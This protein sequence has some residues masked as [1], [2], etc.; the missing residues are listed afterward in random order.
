M[1]MFSL[2]K[3]TGLTAMVAGVA[4]G[5]ASVG[6]DFKYQG[7][8]SLELKQTR[9]SD[10]QALFGKPNSVEMKETSEGKFE[11]VRYLYAY[12]D[13]GS[14]RSRVL[15]MEFRDGTLN[16]YHYLSSF[17]KDKTTVN[18]DQLKQIQRGVSKKEDV[19]QLLG[20]PHG[21]ALCPSYDADFK[22]KCGKGA[23]IWLWTVMGKASTFGVAYGGD[24]I[25]VHNIFVIFD[26]DG[27]VT[28]VESSQTKNT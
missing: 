8:G 15:D 12:A 21:K 24:Q 1:N 26:K 6:K 20:K 9:S 17:D 19:L 13:M 23:E 28:E 5:C 27:V 11:L 16:S 25:E 18:A 10:Y 14:A 2:L 4:C 7:A 3:L 22:D